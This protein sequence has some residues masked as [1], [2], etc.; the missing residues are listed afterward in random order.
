MATGHWEWESTSYQAGARTPASVGFTR[1]LVFGA[2]G[3]LTVHR[4]GQADYHTTYQLSMS[5]APLI[6]F[7]NETDLPN[8]NTKTYTLRSP[9]Y[10]QQVLSLMGVTVPVDGGAV[11]TYH[12]VS[13]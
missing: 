11:E 5:Y 1:Q 13:E 2:G 3:Q 7:V 12:W 6:T 10:G 8:D 4:S 9:Q